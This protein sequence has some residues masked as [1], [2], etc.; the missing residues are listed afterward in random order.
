MPLKQNTEVVLSSTWAG[1]DNQPTQ[2]T[3]THRTALLL[4]SLHAG[5]CNFFLFRYRSLLIP[6]QANI[7]QPIKAMA[8]QIATT[9]YLSI[10]SC[11]KHHILI[12]AALWATLVENR[13]FIATLPHNICVLGNANGLFVCVY[14][15]YCAH[16]THEDDPTMLHSSPP[17]MFMFSVFNYVVVIRYKL[18]HCGCGKSAH[19]T[20]GNTENENRCRSDALAFRW[21]GMCKNSWATHALPLTSRRICCFAACC[22]CSSHI[23]R[24]AYALHFANVL[25]HFRSICIVRMSNTR[26][27]FAPPLTVNLPSIEVHSMHNMWSGNSAVIC[28]NH[29]PLCLLLLALVPAAAHVLA[30]NRRNMKTN[31]TIR[32]HCNWCCE[33]VCVCC[34]VSCVVLYSLKLS[35]LAVASLCLC[36]PLRQLVILWSLLNEGIVMRH[37]LRSGDYI[38]EHNNRRIIHALYLCLSMQIMNCEFPKAKHWNT[39]Q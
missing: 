17:Y 8:T 11:W 27:T 30:S 9:F 6:E 7:N 21:H 36:S 15:H 35:S 31:K 22:S 28:R 26:V 5:S 2:H 39:T 23:T 19:R 4:R 32:F 16:M 29:R 33:C 37:M 38:T 18:P 12:V 24:K 13:R 34:A 1:P 3:H 25:C 14:A 10:I 20:N